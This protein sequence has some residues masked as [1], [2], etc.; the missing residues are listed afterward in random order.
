MEEEKKKEALKNIA[1]KTKL[2]MELIKECTKIADEAKVSFSFDIA[3]GMGGTYR[4]DP[5]TR[6]GEDY[7]DDGWHASSYSC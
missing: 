4:G 7:H 3:Y 6:R 1:E 2:A 5:E